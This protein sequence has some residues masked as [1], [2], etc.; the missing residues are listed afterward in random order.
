M[1]YSSTRTRNEVDGKIFLRETKWKF[2]DITRYN[3]KTWGWENRFT[4]ID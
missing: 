1:Q 2:I 4:W 3:F